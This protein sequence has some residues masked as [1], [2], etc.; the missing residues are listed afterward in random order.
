MTIHFFDG[1]KKSSV[2]IAVGLFFGITIVIQAYQC[3]Y[4]RPKVNKEWDEIVKDTTN[5]F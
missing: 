3:F 2:W 5:R 1:C 4:R